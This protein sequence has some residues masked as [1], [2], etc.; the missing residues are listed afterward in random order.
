M[1]RTAAEAGLLDD[2]PVEEDDAIGRKDVVAEAKDVDRGREKGLFGGS[3][4][5]WILFSIKNVGEGER[6]CGLHR[7]GRA[8]VRAVGG[9]VCP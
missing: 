8:V 2:K 9:R 6:L 7:P 4:H 5:V 1:E 3:L